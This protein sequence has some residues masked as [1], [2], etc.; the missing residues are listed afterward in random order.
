MG[1]VCGGITLDVEEEMMLWH[2]DSRKRRKH[3]S[4]AIMQQ[5]Y[6]EAE[7]MPTA[8]NSGFS[9]A[10]QSTHFVCKQLKVWEK[11]KK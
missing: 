1:E 5:D 3:P 4:Q 10:T 7:E 9:Y 6:S 11:R 2:D 8:F